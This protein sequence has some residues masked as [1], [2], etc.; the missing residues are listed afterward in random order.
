MGLFASKVAGAEA[1]ERAGYFGSGIYTV[2]VD[3]LK[4]IKTRKGEDALVIECDVLEASGSTIPVGSRRS[5]IIMLSWESGPAS[6]KKAIAAISGCR[7]D[8]VDEEG[9][10]LAISDE[11]PLHGR[12]ARLECNEVETR[13]GGTFTQHLWMAI[14]ESAQ[15]KSADLRAKA[16]LP[17]LA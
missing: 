2:Q 10:D 16:G 4:A 7:V 8:E 15:A 1:T 17:P 13:K 11:Q 14:P 6:I 9:I 12:L 3:Q 5:Q